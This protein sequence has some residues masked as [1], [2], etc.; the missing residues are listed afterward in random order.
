MERFF[1]LFPWFPSFKSFFVL[2]S[3]SR[4]N[5]ITDVLDMTFSVDEEQFGKVTT[6]DL[7]PNGRNVGVTNENKKEYVGFE[8][9]FQ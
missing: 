2:F 5:D 6:F 8:S 3:F 4:D 7:I 1:L 9:F